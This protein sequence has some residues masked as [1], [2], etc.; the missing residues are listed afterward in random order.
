[1]YSQQTK[2]RISSLEYVRALLDCLEYVRTLLDCPSSYICTSHPTQ[3]DRNAVFV[4]DSSSLKAAD[5]IKCD[6]CGAW[7]QTKTATVYVEIDFMDCGSVLSVKNV[8]RS[9]QQKIY[10]LFC[11][12]YTCLSSPDL[13]RRIAVI[14]LLCGKTHNLQYLQYKFSG[15]EHPI[16]V[17]PHGN[18]KHST[19]SYRC[20]CPSTLSDLEEEL[21]VYPPKRAVFRVDRER[22]GIFNVRCEGDLPRNSLQA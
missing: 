18:A 8:C 16:E 10:S 4:I 11:R 15:E 6:D 3:F 12:H 19:K 5:D 1:M 13:T 17:K 22:G 9:S 21:K 2:Q 7:R 14:T 20:T